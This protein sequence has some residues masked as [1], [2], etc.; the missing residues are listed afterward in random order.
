MVAFDAAALLLLL[1]PTASGSQGVTKCRERIEFYLQT[2]SDSGERVLIP[3]PALAE[4][5]VGAGSA[6]AKYVDELSKTRAFKVGVFDERAAI[7]V[8]CLE[9]ADLKSGRKLSKQQTHAKVKYDRQIIAI[10]KINSADTICTDDEN[11]GKRAEANGLIVK[12]LADL[13]LPPENPQR[14]LD[15]PT[16]E[17]SG[18]KPKT[19]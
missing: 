16:P 17:Q 18:G 19:N 13:P 9:D 2:L 6:R 14:S 8:A 12:K 1:D 7:E 15:L 3:T 4:V 11:L 5:L 10:A